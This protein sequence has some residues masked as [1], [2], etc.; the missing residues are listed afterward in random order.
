MTERLLP[1]TVVGSYPQPDWLLDRARLGTSVARVRVR[2]LWRG[3]E[4]APGGDRGAGR[5]SPLGNSSSQTC[6][7]DIAHDNIIDAT[8]IV[9]ADVIVIWIEIEHGVGHPAKGDGGRRRG[10]GI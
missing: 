2:G 6:A 1:T 3:A 5:N 7:N 9:I 8:N 4:L 10:D